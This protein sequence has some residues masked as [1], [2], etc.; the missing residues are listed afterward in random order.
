MCIH[1]ISCVFLSGYGF[2][3]GSVLLI[4]NANSAGVASLVIM[5]TTLGACSGAV[6]GMFFAT[7]LDYRSTG[8]VTY[9]VAATMNGCLTGLVAITAGCATVETWAAVVIGIFAGL[10]YCL[11]SRLL[12]AIRFDDAVDAVPVHLV[13]GAWGLISTGLLSSPTLIANAYGNGDHAGWFYDFSDFTLCGVQLITVL[14]IIAWCGTVMGGWF[15]FLNYMGWYRVD[16]LEE[17]AGLDISRHKG[18]AYDYNA[19]PDGTVK[20][21]MERRESQKIL[22]DNSRRGAPAPS[23]EAAVDGTSP[24]ED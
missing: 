10:F 14:F 19:P 9:D 4:A 18:S 6:F 1:P 20:E 16:E 12:V 3:P 23:E 2:N 13:G 11:G 5:N 7:L 8:V 24:T 22:S 15:A 17:H 21:L